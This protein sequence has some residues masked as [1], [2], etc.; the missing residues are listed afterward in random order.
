[1]NGFFSWKDISIDLGLDES[2]HGVY[3]IGNWRRLRFT[4]LVKSNHT[5]L[6]V[7]VHAHMLLNSIAVIEN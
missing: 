7:I 2:N 6:V 5:E 4:A 1:M 3:G